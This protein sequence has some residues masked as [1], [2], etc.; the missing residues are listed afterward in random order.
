MFLRRIHDCLPRVSECTDDNKGASSTIAIAN[1]TLIY[2]IFLN[3][4]LI[5]KSQRRL[6]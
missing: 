6:A 1:E 5:K 3:V 2:F 4:F